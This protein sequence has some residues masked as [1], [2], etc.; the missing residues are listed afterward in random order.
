MATEFTVTLEDRPGSLAGLTGALA[1]YAVNITAIHATPCPDRG[2]V[3]FITDHPDATLEALQE[4]GLDYTTHEVLLMTLIDQP[5]SL[6]R[7]AH[8]L[9]EAEIN[10]NALY[11]TIGGQVVLD[12]SDVR[13]AQQVVL[14]LG[15]S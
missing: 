8:A 5:G 2:I 14:A 6:S 11:I 9:G 12:V 7:L 10:I 1:K 3:Q 15:I 13:R 4:A